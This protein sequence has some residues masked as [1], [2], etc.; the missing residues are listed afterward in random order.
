[1]PAYYTHYLVAR[2]TFLQSPPAMKDTVRPFL[3]LYFF[4]AQGADF[5]FFYNSL[6]TKSPNFGSYLHRAGGYDA[7]SVLRLFAKK[8]AEILAYALGFITHYAA[9]STF[10][11]YVYAISGNSP[12][13]HNRNESLI[14]AYFTKRELSPDPYSE[15]AQSKLSIEDEEELFFV[16][17][18]IAARCGLPPL[19][20][21]PFSRAISVFN[22][23]LPITSTLAKGKTD[24]ALQIVANEEKL[25]WRYP[26]DPSITKTDDIQ[27]L[28]H[29]SV[30]KSLSLQKSFFH[31]VETNTQLPR[32]TFGKSFLTGI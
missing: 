16:Y 7:F 19:F 14:D 30:K 20:K 15:Y 17:A 27:S 12:V 6:W 28:F 29:K 22:A 11:P 8:R 1:M 25:P 13:K 31:A 5:C 21:T 32:A 3:P 24:V 9:D 23:Y 2:E 26:A 18:A 10:H 4:G